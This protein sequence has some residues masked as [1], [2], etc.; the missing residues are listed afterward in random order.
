MEF[1]ALQK[2]HLKEVFELANNTLGNNYITSSYLK[3]YLNSKNY[4][5]FV[6]LENNKVIAFISIVILSPSTLKKM[7]L[8]ENDWFYKL[9]KNYP[10]IA[11]QKQTIVNP[12]FTNQ[13]IGTKLVKLS[14]KEVTPLTDIQLSTV[15][16]KEGDLAMEKLLLKND[17]RLIKTIQNYWYKDSL[18]NNYNCL[19]CGTP[20]CKCATEVYIKKNALVKTSAFS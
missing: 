4:L 10:K 17:F 20:P 11:L 12:K 13:G 6:L 8:K 5:G 3:Q 18:N 14:I 1:T 19:I 7:V 16:K 15:W 9:A 2:E